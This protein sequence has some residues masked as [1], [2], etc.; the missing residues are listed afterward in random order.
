MK[1]SI[2]AACLV[3]ST[4]IILTACSTVRQANSGFLVAGGENVDYTF[5]YPETW[6]KTRDDGMI[7]VKSQ[8]SA[9]SV[10][11]TAFRPTEDYASIDEYFEKYRTSF[12]ETLG[13]FSLISEEEISLADENAKKISYTATV[14]D[15][16]YKFASVICIRNKIVYTITYTAS[17]DDY[18]AHAPTLAHIIQSFEFD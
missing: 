6:E 17:E 3:V 2:V 14:M 10:S 4:S 1:R 12:E 13:N 11:V 8:D 18:D 7:A 16:T 9:A 5:E 15:A